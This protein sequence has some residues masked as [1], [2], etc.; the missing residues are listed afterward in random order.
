M[1]V[2]R[3]EPAAALLQLEGRRAARLLARVH[4]RFGRKIFVPA[5][6]DGAAMERYHVGMQAALER[7]TEFAEGQVA[8]STRNRRSDAAMQ[9]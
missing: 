3:R 8:Q 4:V 9:R 1:Q 6:A 2:M 5:D 7:V